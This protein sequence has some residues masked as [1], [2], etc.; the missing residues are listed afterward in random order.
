LI[1]SI[2]R[3][4]QIEDKTLNQP[5]AKYFK[6]KMKCNFVETEFR[7]AGVRLD[8]LAYN[9]DEK[10]FYICEGK[11]AK[12]KTQLFIEPEK[13]KMSFDQNNDHPREVFSKVTAIFKKSSSEINLKN[14]K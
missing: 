13:E 3:K 11:N 6:K 4:N 7:Y 9:S 12:S 8:V 2:K 5:A 1:K 14:K 10:C